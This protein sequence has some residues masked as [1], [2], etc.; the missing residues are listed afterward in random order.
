MPEQAPLPCHIGHTGTSFFPSSWFVK[1]AAQHPKEND[2]YPFVRTSWVHV[3]PHPPAHGQRALRPALSLPGGCRLPRCA[4]AGVA[5]PQTTL[6][7]LQRMAPVQWPGTGQNLFGPHPPLT[8]IASPRGTENKTKQT[9][10]SLA[11][12]DG[13]S[14]VMTLN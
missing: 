4:A 7:P 5:S 8:E 6:A 3:L 13:T 9:N 1:V 2:K 10:R 12:P 14:Q 11:S